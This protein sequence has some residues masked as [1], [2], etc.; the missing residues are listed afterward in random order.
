MGKKKEAPLSFIKTKEKQRYFKTL[1][2][3][4]YNNNA[5]ALAVRLVRRFKKQY[6]N[7]LKEKAAVQTCTKQ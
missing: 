3:C 6:Q 7:A 5:R 4:Y 1:E 2:K